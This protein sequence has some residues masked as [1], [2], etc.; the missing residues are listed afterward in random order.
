MGAVRWK[1]SNLDLARKAV[2]YKVVCKGAAV[3]VED[4]WLCDTLAKGSKIP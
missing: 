1:Y 2:V 4:L 3:A